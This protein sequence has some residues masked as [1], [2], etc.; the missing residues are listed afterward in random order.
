[1]TTCDNVI[2]NGFPSETQKHFGTLAEE[3][4]EASS[5]RNKQVISS[6]RP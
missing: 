6:I 4:V 5:H 3:L 2:L 1:M